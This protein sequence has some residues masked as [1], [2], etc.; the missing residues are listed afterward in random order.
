MDQIDP[1]GRQA[2]AANSAVGREVLKKMCE[3]RGSGIM[4]DI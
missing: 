3:W 2:Q 4:N 1:Q